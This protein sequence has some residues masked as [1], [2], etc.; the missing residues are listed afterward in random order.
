MQKVI[1]VEIVPQAIENAKENAKLNN[2]DNAEFYCGG[3]RNSPGT[4]KKMDNA[5][6]SDVVVVDL[7]GLDLQHR[8]LIR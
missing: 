2:V 8:L 3:R 4:Y 1:G 5:S 6:G 7:Q